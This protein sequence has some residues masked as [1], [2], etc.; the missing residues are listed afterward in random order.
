MTLYEEIILHHYKFH[1]K[2]QEPRAAM[3]ISVRQAEEAMATLD[4]KDP[5]S[6]TTYEDLVL[7][8]LCNVPQVRSRAQA[9]RAAS[10]YFLA[11][12]GKS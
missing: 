12:K 10:G 8:T 3:D 2:N 7:W 1:T 11:L 4:I 6:D 5:M 9:T